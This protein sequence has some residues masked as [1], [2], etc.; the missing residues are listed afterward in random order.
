V[1][2][3]MILCIA[4]SAFLAVG[5]ALK[6]DTGTYRI[7]LYDVDLTPHSDGTVAIEYHQR[8]LVTGGHIPWITVGTANGHF[9]IVSY[10]GAAR[11]ASSASQSGWSGVR[12][13]LDRDYQP[14]QTF[15]VAFSIA[16]S[17]LFYGEANN[18]KLDFTPGWYDRAATDTLRLGVALFAKPQTV[19]ASPQPS[20]IDGDRM[21]WNRYALRPGERFTVHITIPVGAFPTAIP[22]GNL[23]GGAGAGASIVA[24]VIAFGGLAFIVL[25]VIL[26]L[27]FRTKRYSGGRMFYGGF[28]GGGSGRGAPGGG[29]S[30][31]GGGGF[32]G[33]SISCACACVSCACACACAGGGGAGCARKL[34]HTCPSCR[35]ERR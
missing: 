10:G 27:V 23:K 17:G 21:V 35:G 4:V 3:L 33:A 16:Q 8:W 24:S 11:E 12:L 26:V 20:F 31:G 14:G 29:R 15:D 13:D 7:L 30:T 2:K 25:L 18:Y 28:F 19:V 5:S 1:K 6:G 9:Q 34:E 32:G 22:S